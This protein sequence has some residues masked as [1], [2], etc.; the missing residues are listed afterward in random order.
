MKK[1]TLIFTII[2]AMSSFTSCG[3]QNITEDLSTSEPSP[4]ISVSET[5]PDIIVSETIPTAESEQVTAPSQEVGYEGMEAVYAE[6][7]KDGIYSITVDSSSPMFNITECE[8]KVENGKMTAVITMGG[9]GYAYIFMG[10]S[11]EAENAAEDEYIGYSEDDTGKHSFTVPVEA[12]NKEISCAAFSKKKEQWYDRLLVFRADSLPV[13]A[14]T[15]G[16]VKTAA[17]LGLE[18]GQ[19]TADVILSGGLG[20]A[21]VES[22]ALITVTEG[23]VIAKIIWNSKNY[24]YMV[25]EGEKYLPL[26][27]EENSAFEIPVASFDFDLP[28][29][30][31]TT[32][33]STPHEIEYTLRFNSSGI[34][35]K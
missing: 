17:D 2:L 31:D 1:H 14:Y 16:T 24:D 32:A 33:M 6:S 4:D 35:K 29:S 30:A 8:L 27:S 18:D 10:T 22:P 26:E 7:I 15:S 28:V 3:T 34:E 19:Y 23:K 13:D 9:T 12:L 21:S 20:R 11:D 5:T 25:V